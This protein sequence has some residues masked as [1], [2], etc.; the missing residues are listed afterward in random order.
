MLSEDLKDGMT[1]RLARDVPNPHPDRRARYDWTKAPVF[2]AGMRFKVYEQ[3]M[4][5]DTRTVHWFVLSHN[6]STIAQAS[7]IWFHILSNCEPDEQTIEDLIG[8]RHNQSWA[9]K[10]VVTTLLADG[11]LTLDDVRTILDKA[12]D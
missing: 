11:R 7:T 3:H 8:A 1:L 4:T 9:Y 6:A 5:V 10:E 2:L 12:E